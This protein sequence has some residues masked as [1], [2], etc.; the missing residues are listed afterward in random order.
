M[1]TRAALSMTAQKTARA[2]LRPRRV[3]AASAERLSN[4]HGVGPVILLGLL[5]TVCGWVV[6]G[7]IGGPVL[8]KV[9]AGC[10][11]VLFSFYII[12]DTQMIVKGNH[13]RYSY[14]ID[15]YVFA[16]LSIYL[17]IVNLFF[18]LLQILGNRR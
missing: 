6:Y 13:N 5:L 10:G 12:F 4:R 11:A 8:Q 18:F 17:D 2:R 14:D 15:D 9:Y 16:A 3:A 7:L 1:N